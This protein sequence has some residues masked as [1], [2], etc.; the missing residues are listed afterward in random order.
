MV[1]TIVEL[2]SLYMRMQEKQFLLT[3]KLKVEQNGLKLCIRAGYIF[4]IIYYPSWLL[5]YLRRKQWIVRHLG[6]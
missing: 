3:Y 6:L 1:L 5:K 4:F 2:P